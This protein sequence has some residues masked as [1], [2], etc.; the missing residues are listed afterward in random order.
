MNLTCATNSAI[1]GEYYYV[2]NT[3]GDI[4]GLID[5]TGAMVASYTYDSWGKLISID[6][7]LKNSV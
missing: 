6:G 7:T 1:N 4:I 2:R 5:K 3:Q